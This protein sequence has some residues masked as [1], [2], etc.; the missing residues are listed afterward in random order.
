MTMAIH[1]PKYEVG[2]FSE[3]E[4]AR[5]QTLE[6]F[7]AGAQ[8]EFAKQFMYEPMTEETISRIKDSITHAVQDYYQGAEIQSIDIDDARDLEF[9]QKECRECAE[10]SSYEEY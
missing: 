8:T 9:K 4:A 1:V 2:E 3:D 10:T 6:E 5:V 7:V